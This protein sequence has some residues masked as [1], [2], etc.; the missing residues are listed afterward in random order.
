MPIRAWGHPTYALLSELDRGNRPEARGNDRCARREGLAGDT[1][2]GCPQGPASLSR[3][4]LALAHSI[5]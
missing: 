1:P 5:E 2:P 4:I 3:G